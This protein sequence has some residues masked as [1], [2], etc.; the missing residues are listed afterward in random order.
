[1]SCMLMRHEGAFGKEEMLIPVP[2]HPRRLR[3]RGYNQALLLAQAISAHTGLPLE[4]E[5]LVRIRMTG[6]LTHSTRM[7]RL[8]AIHGAFQADPQRLRGKHL[9][10]IDD[11]FTTG[12][13]SIACAMTMLQ[14]GA[15]EVS[16]LTACRTFPR[17]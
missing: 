9:L 5:A 3:E 16:V 13:T 7:Q 1:M 17:Q 11:V 2:L 10:L 14:A 6:A 12:A 8:R 4:R 15:K